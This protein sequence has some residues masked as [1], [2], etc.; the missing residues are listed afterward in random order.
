[1][2]IPSNP[3]DAFGSYS[4]KH[5]LIAFQYGQ[6][7]FQYGISQQREN[8]SSD[9]PESGESISNIGRNVVVINEFKSTGVAIEQAVWDFDFIPTVGVSTS[10]S[11]GRIVVAD[12]LR[13]YSFIDFLKITVLRN[14]NKGLGNKAG[15]LSSM[16]FMLRT[17]FST[18][19]EDNIIVNP[20]FFTIDS[21]ES[22]PK[23]NSI[24]P[25]HHILNVIGSINSLGLLKSFGSMHQISITHRD[26]NIH[27]EIPSGNGRSGLRTRSEENSSNRARRKSRLEKSKPMRSL[28]DVFQGLE[29]DLNQLAQ[30][31]QAQLQKWLREIRDDHKDKIVVSPKQTKQPEPEVLP[32][33]F[34]IDLDRE[35]QSSDYLIDNRNMPFE[36]PDVSQSEKGLTVFPVRCGQDLYKLIDNIMML[37]KQVGIDALDFRFSYKTTITAI[38]DQNGY[39]INVK[40]RKYAVP[41]N[42]ADENTGPGLAKRALEFVVNGGGTSL[43]E[44][45]VNGSDSNLNSDVFEFK[46]ILNYRVGDQM[47]EEQAENTPG[48]NIVYADREQATAERRPDIPFFQTLYSGIRPIIGADRIDGLESAQRAGDIMNLMDPYSYTQTTDYELIIRGNPHLLSDLNRNPLD[49]VNDNTGPCYLYTKPETNPMY[50]KLT[51]F[52]RSKA[53]GINDNIDDTEIGPSYF[54]DFYHVTHVVNMFNRTKGGMK[55]F[56]Q[57]IQLRR[58]DDLI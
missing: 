29:A 38:R 31:H 24:S 7:A 34:T 22:I 6:D 1:M 55:S 20:Y 28:Q 54:N 51:V 27:N 42:E 57:H 17:F 44:S 47:L 11:V 13:P 48:A 49:V 56:R 40:I 39:N 9:I 14:L 53:S 8:N 35:Y 15:T 46:S 30:P 12:R 37:S 25:I 58:S 4:I 50:M 32:M 33:R 43:V 3:L 18:N 5:Q 36:Q 52:L 10:S 19:E 45:I 16:T 26:G 2:S 41:K 23:K 21:I